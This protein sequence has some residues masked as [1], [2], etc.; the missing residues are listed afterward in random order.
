MSA[1]SVTAPPPPP[2]ARGARSRLSLLGPVV[3]RA[4]AA[5]GA[6]GLLF[7]S[8]PP[9]PLWFLAPVGIAVLVGVLRGRGLR[10]GFGYGYLAGLGFL[11]PLLPWVGVYVGAVPWLAL[12]GFEALAVGLFGAATALLLR[13]PAAPVWVACAWVGTEALR[14]RVPLNGFPW[15]RLA[16]GQADGVLLPLARLGGAPL[17]SFA[18][19]LVG[20]CLP[21]LR[22]GTRQRWAG[23]LVGVL[24]PVLVALALAPQ[25]AATTADGSTRRL[26]VVQGNV[27]RLGLDFNAQRAAVLGNHVAA[28]ERLAADVAAGRVLPPDLVVWPENASDID[29]LRN[30][31]AAAAL[32]RAAR[33]VGVPILVGTVLRN[34]DGTTRNT[35]LVWD[36]VTGPGD[37]HDK[38]VLVPFGEYLPAADLVTTFFPV[39]ARAG[40]FVPGDGN[41]TV[42][43]NGVPVAVGICYEIAFDHLVTDSV[44]AGAQ[45][46]TV[47]SNNATFG[48][49][50]MT[51]QQLA[52]SQVRAVEHGRTAAVAA[53]SG[54]S[55]IIDPAGRVVDA[56]AVFT[57]DVLVQDVVLRTELT[58]A[59]RLGGAP[60]IVLVVLAAAALAAAALRSRPA[61]PRSR[62]RSRPPATITPSF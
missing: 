49:T 21:G 52:M 39:A 38:R 32:D 3:L 11:L 56:T 9:R 33:A 16:F 43:L 57:A 55:A 15:G 12:A 10:A 25:V 19:V 46:L 29:P 4:G 48:R 22:R 44:R 26:A 37:S 17:L 7:V 45:L 31:D 61:R 36:P 54:V 34:D 53:T 58:P 13:L 2:G 50:E 59:T 47:P 60:E 30:P 14:S 8:F 20:A 51:Y 40:N 41:G 5:A 42:V 27:P 1:V 35:V 18:V 6:G 24:A 23:H 62:P 28:T